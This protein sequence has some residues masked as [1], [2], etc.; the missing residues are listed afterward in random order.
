VALGRIN[1]EFP[2]AG[3]DRSASHQHVRPFTTQD[4]LNVRPYDVLESR[5]R[6][7]S[8][9]GL[10]K[11]FS[12]ELGSGAYVNLLALVRTAVVT[13]S[14]TFQDHF[15]DLNDWTNAPWDDEDLTQS[16]TALIGSTTAGNRGAVYK[17]SALDID[18]NTEVTITLNILEKVFN[19]YRIYTRMNQSSPDVS[20]SIGCE[21]A[22]GQ[23]ATTLSLLK[24]DVIVSI[25]EVSWIP[26]PFD[27]PGTLQFL[28]RAD[29]AFGFVRYISANQGGL[30]VDDQGGFL[31][32]GSFPSGDAIAVEIE[33]QDVNPGV[34]D[35]VLVA[36][37][38]ENLPPQSQ[39]VAGSNGTLYSETTSGALTVIT[40]TPTFVDRDVESTPVSVAA[41]FAKLYIAD[42]AEPRRERTAT[43]ANA[44]IANNSGELI[45]SD[46]DFVTDG[47]V[48]TGDV[49]ELTDVTGTIATGWYEVRT[50]TDLNTLVLKTLV[51][52]PAAPTGDSTS[53]AYRIVPGIKIYDA[54]T[55]AVTLMTA[56]GAAIVSGAWAGTA[57]YACRI[58]ELY[59]DRLVFSGDP[60]NPGDVFMS[61]QGDPLN[62]DYS[63]ATVT[64]QD[65]FAFDAGGLGRLGAPVTSL[66]PVFDDLMMVAGEGECSVL[67]GDP[68]VGGT[69][70][71]LSRRVGVLS[72]DAWAPT[73]D[74]QIYFLSIDGLYRIHRTE[75]GGLVEPRRVSPDRIPDELRQIDPD[76]HHVFLEYDP[77]Y[78]GIWIRVTSLSS[79]DSEAWWYDMRLEG[80]FHDRYA[81]DHDAF[82]GVI[83]DLPNRLIVGC[84]DGRVR[85]YSRGAADDDGTSFTSYAEFGPIRLDGR[86]RDGYLDSV[87]VALGENSGA[88]TLKVRSG[89]TPQAAKNAADF[90]TRSLAAGL[91]PS[92]RPR[93]RGRD[94]YVRI[95]NSG[96]VRWALEFMEAEVKPGGRLRA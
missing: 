50:V 66:I 70:D 90:A 94:A 69:F 22:F 27:T 8:R 58:V 46:A 19:K 32:L 81:E 93:M 67:R 36:Y 51:A 82:C 52:T 61:K 39:I 45:D 48:A 75:L 2:L 85:K 49:I 7:G 96:D 43:S 28:I 6:G 40:G 64:V 3:I 63:P 77:E 38:A 10:A 73:D 14:R 95:Q 35:A 16:G 9:P 74:D 21:I 5:A 47:V 78:L 37:T 23:S 24:N 4:A 12:E 33:P 87:D 84:R 62:Y 71:H 20:S 65:A 91:N 17:T 13:P 76:T 79:G 54:T 92:F 11:A 29:T 18:W 68:A 59:R 26:E 42:W 80:F 1:L 41:R 56:T 60:N 72:F 57:P 30:F 55:D 15:T 88:C 86:G 31:P 83:G 53:T 44:A 25:L 89:K 34:I